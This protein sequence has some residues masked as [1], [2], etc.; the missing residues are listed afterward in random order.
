M[1]CDV[2]GRCKGEMAGS[3]GKRASAKTHVHV[4]RG[5]GGRGHTCARGASVATTMRVVAADGRTRP[6]PMVSAPSY[7]Y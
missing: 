6:R 2:Q 5:A 3:C 7:E 4:R 1:Q